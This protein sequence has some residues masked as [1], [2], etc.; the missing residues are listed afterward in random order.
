MTDGNRQRAHRSRTAAIS[1]VV[2]VMLSLTFVPPAAA[3]GD[4]TG[5]PPT[6]GP[7]AIQGVGTGVV[8]Q[9]APD[10]CWQPPADPADPA[11]YGHYAS[12]TPAL[13]NGNYTCPGGY[14]PKVD[15]AYVW[16]MTRTNS[17]STGDNIWF[18]TVA[19][20]LCLVVGPFLGVT[21]PMATNT[22]TCEFA[23]SPY[24]NAGSPL[25]FAVPAALGDWRPPELYRYAVG[26]GPP[27]NLET[28]NS[29]ASDATIQQYLD[30]TV[31]IRSAGS[32][33][34]PYS[35]GRQVVFF[36]GP[37][38][39]TSGGITILAFHDDGAFIGATVLPEYNDIRNWVTVGTGVQ[40]ALYAGVGLSNGQGGAVLRWTPVAGGF[41]DF[42]PVATIPGDVAD[43]VLAGDRLVAGTWPNV[44]SDL[45]ADGQQSVQNEAAVYVSPGG[46]PVADLTTADQWVKAWDASD[47]EPDATIAMTYGTGAM[48]YYDGFL[49]W[50]TMHVPGLAAEAEVRRQQQLGSAPAPALVVA[51]VVGSN[52]AFSLF[53]MSVTTG[54]V[55]LLY[56]AARLPA[57]DTTSG[58]WQLVP[59]NMGGVAGLYGAPGFGNVFNNYD[60][61]MAVYRNQLYVGTMDWSYLASQLWTVL[62]PQLGLPSG[63]PDPL[64]SPASA[65]RPGAIGGYGADLYRFPSTQ[66]AAQALFT[67]G[68]GNYLTYGI[69][70]MLATGTGSADTGLYLGMANPMNLATTGAY[71]PGGWELVDLTVGNNP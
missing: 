7:G 27:V 42:T 39:S 62:A 29:P 49:Y 34:D 68:V 22:W 14:Q 18:G 40:S 12:Q 59:N 19:N 63:T 38:L 46:V 55:Q 32:V 21:T 28:L 11:D 35:A 52:R 69:R 45:V 31:G 70:N 48:A 2:L 56:G 20:T 54:A 36:A 50:G 8:G 37:T 25:G 47:Y 9:A 4:Q 13:V 66:S 51:D 57:F 26:G 6:A 33:P 53:R 71:P 61:S 44:Q 65:P 23:S 15:Q 3:A 10:E 41:F 16:G 64:A 60:W 1:M 67:N 17:A 24:A 43:L 5:A 30:H 58:A